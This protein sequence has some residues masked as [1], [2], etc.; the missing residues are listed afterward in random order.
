METLPLE[1]KQGI[2]A[3]LPDLFSLRSSAL[4]CSSLHTAFR[5]DKQNIS[6]RVVSN[7]IHPALIN[8]AVVVLESSRTPKSHWT[9]EQL[10]D[11]LARYTNR[12][13]PLGLQHSG[14]GDLASLDKFQ[15]CVQYLEFHFASEML[16]RKETASTACSSSYTADLAVSQSELIRIERALYRFEMYCNL[17]GDQDDLP[18]DPVLDKH[19]KAFF[20]QLSP[21]EFE[22]LAC[23]HDCLVRV[24]RSG[25]ALDEP[26]LTLYL[27]PATEADP[28]L[29]FEDL[30]DHVPSWLAIFVDVGP[31]F[32]DAFLQDQ[33]SRGLAR[34]HT[35][36]CTEPN[37]RRQNGFLGM[38]EDRGYRSSFLEY[39]LQNVAV[40]KISP[41]ELSTMDQAEQDVE[42]NNPLARDPDSGP[43]DVWR[44]A[45]QREAAHRF[46]YSNAQARLRE[47]GYVMWDR[48]R[49]EGMDLFSKA[50]DG[51]D[52]GDE[53]RFRIKEER[54]RVLEER[55]VE[56]ERQG[57]IKGRYY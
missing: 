36:L 41:Y 9:W 22:Q 53:A 52:E 35:I 23:V 49:L 2:L 4:T 39:G 13:K 18:L 31:Y 57:R 24:Y 8:D 30:S 44:W 43:E 5:A 26:C 34:L 28:C 11:F 51:V 38:S 55:L 50:W 15:R 7:Q 20:D 48:A 21:W 56:W 42:T 19:K 16:A 6:R 17:F 3:A 46:T 1:L 54:F 40:Y 27:Q 14:S 12:D 25:K 47:W 32:E 45:H 10:L 33:L 37:Q 29:V